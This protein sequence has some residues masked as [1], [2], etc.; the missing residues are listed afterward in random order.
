MIQTQLNS[1]KRSALRRQLG[2]S[3]CNAMWYSEIKPTYLPEVLELICRHHGQ[4]ELYA[5]LISSIA[6]L[7]SMVNSNICN[8]KRLV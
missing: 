2:I 4:G 8:S 5:A 6:A 1:Q 3:Q 7:F